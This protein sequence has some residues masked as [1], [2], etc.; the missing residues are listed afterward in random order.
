MSASTHVPRQALLAVR[1]RSALCSLLGAMA[2]STRV[3]RCARL[4]DRFSLCVQLLYA[5]IWLLAVEVTVER[6]ARVR[7]RALCQRLG[8]RT[9]TSAGPICMPCAA[10]VTTRC[11][12]VQHDGVTRCKLELTSERADIP[13]HPASPLIPA[14]IITLVCS[15][16]RSPPTT[17]QA[18]PRQHIERGCLAVL[19]WNSAS[20]KWRPT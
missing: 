2:R 16:F 19:Q 12:Y 20:I 14:A 1:C 13:G 6:F 5:Y 7:P 18:H 11:S 17:Q 10:C 4:V 8:L 15:T 9:I 3:R